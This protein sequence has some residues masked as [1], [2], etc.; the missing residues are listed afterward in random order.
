MTP[1]GDGVYAPAALA[2]LLG[3]LHLVLG[4]LDLGAGPPTLAATLVALNQ[5]VLGGLLL[6]TAVGL[7]RGRPW[8]RFLGVVCFSGIALVQLLPLV[9]GESPAVPLLGILLGSSAALYLVLA[10]GAFGE[11]DGRDLDEDTDPHD[12]VR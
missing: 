3:G 4:G 7:A 9:S 1:D 12:F 5:V 11:D 8:S 10:P 2:I 6:P